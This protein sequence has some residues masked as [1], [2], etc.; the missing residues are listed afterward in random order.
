MK[1]L[2]LAAGY[3]T[4]L[5]PYSD[6]T[7]KP[8]FPID[9]RPLLDRLIRQL[10][11]GG[12]E[13]VMVNTHH[14]HARIDAF[15]QSRQYPVPVQTRFEPQILG[16]GGAI[17]NLA[18]FWDKRPFLVVN[19]DILTDIDPA[20]VYRFHRGHPD[21]VTLALTDCPRFNTVGVSAQ[22]TVTDFGGSQA[23]ARRLTFTGIQ[24]LDP[25]LLDLIPQGVFSSSID[26]FRR[27]IAGGRE[28]RAFVPGACQWDDLGTPDRYRRAARDHL[29]VRAFRV[30]W[31]EAPPPAAAAIDCRQLAGDGSDRSWYRL[32][33]GERTLVLAD[34]GIRPSL[35]TCEADAFI[36]IGRH[37]HQKGVPV[38][39]I[40]VHDA[41]SGLVF[42]EDLG[43]CNLQQAAHRCTSAGDL[44][45]L[46]RRVID[47]ALPLWTRGAVGFDPAWGYQGP[48]FDRELILERECRYFLTAFVGG[49]LGWEVSPA[50]YQAEFSALA[51]GLL[52]HG[53]DGLIHRDLQSRN[54]MWH[55]DGPWFIDF[56]GARPGPVQYDL[57][58][59]LI[60]PYVELP[61]PVQEGLLAYACRRLGGDHPERFLA[62]YAYCA[63]SRNLQMLGAFG[64]LS[65]VKGK[66]FF[67]AYIPAAV[68]A[69][70]HHF[71]A[72][73]AGDFNRL[74]DLAGRLARQVGPTRR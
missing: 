54:I 53:C 64:H 42:M 4:R 3:G 66:P 26:A 13:A 20:A 6:H 11:A 36:A 39:V 65:R 43:D 35:E 48:R 50:E 49:Y 69:L 52:A 8:L 44:T 56:Q 31:P 46:Y 15:L 28:I 37:L 17:Q 14:L 34:H 73:P 74:K 57:A 63:L 12:C 45:A 59:L 72:P 18:D 30:R 1:A 58:A 41:F 2:I 51:D 33:W 7:P 29:A 10:I 24:V 5:R 68:R 60:D 32:S 16:T 23:A 38:P 40:G 19:G 21:P 71:E 61:Q 25:E 22:G 55:R 9:G 67:E 27:L 70:Q 62:G 47:A